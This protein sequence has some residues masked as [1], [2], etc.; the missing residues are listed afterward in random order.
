MAFALEQ[1]VPELLE[2]HGRGEGR[3]PQHFDH[4]AEQTDALVTRVPRVFE[5]RRDGGEEARAVRSTVHHERREARIRVEID[6]LTT[7][8][9]RRH[10]RAERR[11][12]AREG[13]TV[14][15]RRDDDHRLAGD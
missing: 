11:Q 13:R 6:V 8:H 15:V 2:A 4:L 3:R 10:V 5:V 1:F 9:A 14:R 7:A 12:P